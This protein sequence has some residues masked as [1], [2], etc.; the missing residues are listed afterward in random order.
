MA[1]SRTEATD[2][3]LRFA[4]RTGLTSA[5]PARRYLWTDA[6][7]VCNFL[8]LGRP[9]LAGQLIDQ[10]H[11]MLGWH[12]ASAGDRRTGRLS[13]LDDREGEAHPTRGGLRIGKPLAERGIG[14]TMDDRLEW[15]QDGQYFHYLTR[16]MYALDRMSRATG[17]PKYTIWA[18][19]LMEVAHRAFVY[20]RG[21]QRRMYWKMS[22]DLSRPLV[23]SMGHHDPLEGYVVC[24]Q[25]ESTAERFGHDAEA[26]AVA[27]KQ[28][29]SMIDRRGLAT[30]D[31]LGIGGML[32]DACR[33]DQLE[34]DRD[35]RDELGMA[36]LVG[37]RH[38]VDQRELEAPASRRLGFRELGLAIGI[39]AAQLMARRTPPPPG[40]EQV[41]RYG[42]VRATI[43]SFWL[44]PE[45]RR[46]ETWLQ[47][48]DISDVMLATSLVPDGYL[49]LG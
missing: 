43:E 17:E 5:L 20:V 15:E 6:F 46:V 16:W 2:L 48:I 24:L 4:E 11:V 35:L 19:E 21:G 26:I 30:T 27:R 38:F 18:R 23:A 37:M 1:D 12:R 32:A 31:P 40:T 34:L 3:M 9:E 33:L 41:S 7:A 8:A 10:V 29:A 14:E 25:L 28:F 13:G 47:H 45:S 42:Y 44:R 39:A 36:S 49:L 22:I